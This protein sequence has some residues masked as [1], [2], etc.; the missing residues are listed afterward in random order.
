M[1]NKKDNTFKSYS[2]KNFLNRSFKNKKGYRAYIEGKYP[3]IVKDESGYGIYGIYYEEE[4]IYIGMTQKGFQSRWKEHLDVFA[5][6]VSR[7]SGMILYQQKMDI[8]KIWFRKIVNVDELNYEGIVG[9][10]ELK[11]MELA[12]ISLFKPKYNVLGVRKPYVI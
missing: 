5:G 11:A 6:I 3:I 9:E 10:Q 7:P 12:C 1:K 2:G 8:N 4:L